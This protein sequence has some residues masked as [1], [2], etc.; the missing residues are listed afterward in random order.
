MKH[1]IKQYHNVLLV[2]SGSFVGLYRIDGNILRLWRAI[3]TEDYGRH[4]IEKYPES[5]KGKWWEQWCCNE[6]HRI[7]IH[8]NLNNKQHLQFLDSL[9]GDYY[10]RVKSKI[11]NSNPETGE[12]RQFNYSTGRVEII[13]QAL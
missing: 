11:E 4:S 10:H 7:P 6:I 1:V 3:N 13:K 5:H 9:L 8:Y 2:R 12:V